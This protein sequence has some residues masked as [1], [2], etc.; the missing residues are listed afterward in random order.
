MEIDLCG[1]LSAPADLRMGQTDHVTHCIRGC[2]EWIQVEYEKRISPCIFVT[3]FIISLVPLH[4]QV[5]LHIYAP[6]KRTG[7]HTM[8]ILSRNLVTTDEVWIGNR[9]YSTL[10]LVTAN[11]YAS[12]T[13]LHAP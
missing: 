1:Q 9:I 3:V 7:T 2:L 8:D 5:S 4:V 6:T 10:T 12:L 11:T 13:E